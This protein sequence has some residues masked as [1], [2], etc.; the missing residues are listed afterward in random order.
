M[1]H[2]S[3]LF[4]FF[5][6]TSNLSSANAWPTEGAGQLGAP[7]SWIGVPDSEG[8]FFMAQRSRDGR[9]YL[10]PNEAFFPKLELTASGTGTVLDVE[11]LNGGKSYAAIEKWDA[12]DVAE[13]GLF[14]ES[15]G[16]ITVRVWMSANRADG[17]FNL[18]IG[19]QKM[20]VV[21]KISRDA[22]LAA[23]T[24]FVIRK[25][26]QQFLKLTCEKSAAGAVLNWIE[27]SGA[28]AKGASVLRKRWRPAAAHTKFSSSRAPNNVRLW[29]MEMDAKPGD[30]GFYSP[31]TTP[32]GYYGPTWQADGTVNAGINFSLWSFGRG[33][34]EPPVEQLSHLLA[35][36][37][38]RAKFGGFDHEGTGVKIRD[39]QPLEGRQGQHQVLALRVEPGEDYDTYFSYSYAADQKRWQLFG[40]GNKF[41]RKKPLKSLWVGSFVEVP[42][43]PHVQRTGAYERAMRYR[44]WV[45]DNDG[46]WY[47]LNQMANGNVNRKT[48]TTHT[49]RGLTDDGWFYLQTG[50]WTFRKAAKDRYVRMEAQEQTP[51]PDYLG[52]EDVAFLKTV[53]SEITVSID[54]LSAKT[55]DGTFRIRNPGRNAEVTVYWGKDEGLT[56]ADRWQNQQIVRSPRE[57]ANTFSIERL[58]GGRTVYVR[59]LLRNDDGQFWSAETVTIN[60][61]R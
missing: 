2:I 36:G 51:V 9:L 37:N 15:K 54:K 1:K 34:P 23:T 17:R 41:N 50:G 28:A 46:A 7:I 4:L 60:P 22:A 26:G 27:I 24:S 21:P 6:V 20:P 31:I 39:W 5:A 43:P 49:D 29:V 16:T 44:G 61:A 38:R 10:T 52:Q 45:M 59:M 12:S 14:F 19:D 56:F 35:I 53:P 55:L 40:V 33:K 13:W 30:L 42:G 3:V 57:N 32:F 47:P 11:N 58:P 25:S 18:Q 48:G 8:A